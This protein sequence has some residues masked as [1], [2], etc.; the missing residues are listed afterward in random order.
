MLLP[1][2]SLIHYP[3]RHVSFCSL[4]P[5]KL[6]KSPAFIGCLLYS[7]FACKQAW[8]DCPICSH[9]GKTG[10]PCPFYPLSNPLYLAHYPSYLMSDF[11]PHS[12]SAPLP[13]TGVNG[14]KSWGHCTEKNYCTDSS[15]RG[16]S[17]PTLFLYRLRTC[18]LFSFGNAKNGARFIFGQSHSPL[19]KR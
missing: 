19:A 18:D 9:G 13:Y 14:L 10:I 11:S 17:F 15:G 6:S 12:L 4:S 3:S 7:H 1:S 8:R 2:F 5:K 16:F